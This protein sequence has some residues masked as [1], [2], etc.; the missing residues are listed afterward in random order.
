MGSTYGGID[1]RVIV[2]RQS[3]RA[4]VTVNIREHSADK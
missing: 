3:G 2:K 4:L 1:Q